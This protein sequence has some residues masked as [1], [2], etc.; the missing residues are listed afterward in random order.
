MKVRLINLCGIVLFL[1]AGSTLIPA[2][3][4]VSGET[5]SD[6]P[7]RRKPLPNYY[8]KIGVSDEQR[9]KLYAVQD[10]YE[11]KLER[12]RKELKDTVQERDQKLELLLTESQRTRLQ[13]LREEAKKNAEAKAAARAS[14]KAAGQ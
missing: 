14:E 3:S 8:G 10:L 6:K 5:A 13:E 7:A 12:L 1:L 4:P 2:A 11:V 9:E